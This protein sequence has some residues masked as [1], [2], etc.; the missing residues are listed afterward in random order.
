[1]NDRHTARLAVYLLLVRDGKVLLTRRYRTG[2]RDGD[3]SMVAGHIEAGETASAATVRE[4]AEEAG[5]AVQPGDLRLVHTMH[6]KSLDYDYIDI[7]FTADTWQGEPRI[8]ERDKCDAMEW[9]PP[10]AM[11]QNTLP[12]VRQGILFALRGVPYSESGWNG[13]AI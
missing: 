1:M 7:F 2:W 3:W 13:D 9:F 10:D 12:Y 8:A 11:P 5:V 6:R 4:A